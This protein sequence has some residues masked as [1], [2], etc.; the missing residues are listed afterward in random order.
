MGGS[1]CLPPD[2]APGIGRGGV[3]EPPARH[4]AK[5][6]RD[7]AD[8]GAGESGTGVAPKWMKKKVPVGIAPT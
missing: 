8:S 4:F 2:P 1:L 7:S 5:G 6:F 3:D